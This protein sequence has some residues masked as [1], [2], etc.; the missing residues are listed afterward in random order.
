MIQVFKANSVT[1]S[2]PG[3]PLTVAF[4]QV[5]PDQRVV[6][7]LLFMKDDEHRG[8]KS[9]LL[10]FNG[11]KNACSGTSIDAVFLEERSLNVRLIRG[12]WLRAGRFD[13]LTDQN[14]REIEARFEISSTKFEQ[15]RSSLETLLSKGCAFH[16]VPPVSR[17]YDPVRDAVEAAGFFT[18]FNRNATVVD[19]MVVASE[20]FENGL[21]GVS[22]A[23][24]RK[25]D[26]WYMSTWGVHIY[27]LPETASV[28]DAVVEALRIHRGTP[29]DFKP[30]LKAKYGLVEVSIEEFDRA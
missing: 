21:T 6:H 22:F 16:V 13:G 11:Q 14:I 24:A 26:S 27:R 29:Y 9:V 12:K 3:E 7:A 19:R 30:E 23:V 18:N 15:V 5:L 8:P 2:G 10:E 17:E 4:G 20:M 28:G 1:V 25:K